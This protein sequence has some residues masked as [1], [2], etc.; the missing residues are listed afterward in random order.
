M[1]SNNLNYSQQLE[2]KVL[3]KS[4]RKTDV[5]NEK[6]LHLLHPNAKSLPQT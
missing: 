6:L 1:F 4:I 5:S 3:D 2:V